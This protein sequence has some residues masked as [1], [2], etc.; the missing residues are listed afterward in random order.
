MENLIQEHREILDQLDALI[1]GK[2]SVPARDV[3]NKIME[4]GDNYTNMVAMCL[5]RV[6]GTLGV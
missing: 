3:A 4:L 5:T 6:S 1:A 2:G